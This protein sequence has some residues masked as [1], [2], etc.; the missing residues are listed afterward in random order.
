[1]PPYKDTI[2]EILNKCELLLKILQ[3]SD[4]SIVVSQFKLEDNWEA[5]MKE[6]YIPMSI[7]KLRK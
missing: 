3:K 5:I 2:K 7:T 1:M 6:K 4:K